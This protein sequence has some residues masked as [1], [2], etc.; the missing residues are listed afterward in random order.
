MK[1][2]ATPMQATL[3]PGAVCRRGRHR[4]CSPSARPT[5]LLRLTATFLQ[6]PQQGGPEAAMNG[7]S[8][9]AHRRLGRSV[10]HQ[11]RVMAPAMAAIG[12]MRPPGKL[13]MPSRQGTGFS[14]LAALS[15]VAGWGWSPPARKRLP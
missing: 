3:S 15:R 13:S 12:A 9:A 7:S 14:A 2:P 1:R 10:V 6:W 8:R 5:G 11:A 4:A